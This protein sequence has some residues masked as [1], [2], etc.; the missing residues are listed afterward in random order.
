MNARILSVAS[1]GLLVASAGC[2]AEG[3]GVGDS[4]R[5]TIGTVDSSLGSSFYGVR[6]RLDGRVEP[7]ATVVVVPNGGA[8]EDAHLRNTPSGVQS[9]AFPVDGT[10]ADIQGFAW[11]GPVRMGDKAFSGRVA[12]VQRPTF[13]T[14]AVS[15]ELVGD[16]SIA[17]KASG[18]AAGSLAG[19]FRATHCLAMDDQEIVAAPNP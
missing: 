10:E 12:I 5:G 4:V 2:S 1:L 15:G 14:N 9:L 18:E 3:D 19:R 16:L 8:C 17:L 13:T 7:T 6:R 11:D